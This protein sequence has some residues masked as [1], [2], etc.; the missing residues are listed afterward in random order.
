MKRSVVVVLSFIGLMACA[1]LSTMGFRARV[2]LDGE[3]STTIE[4]EPQVHQ[5]RHF[6]TL[7]PESSDVVL[8]VLGDWG[9]GSAIQRDVARAM[10]LHARGTR[11]HAIIS[12][13]DNFYPSGVSS[14]SDRLFR[15][16]WEKTY[17]DSSLQVQWIVALG[18]HDYRG[19][20]AAQLEYSRLQPRWY[21]PAPYYTT[22][23]SAGANVV[24]LF[25][26]DTDSLL[27]N[28]ANRMRQLQWLDSVLGNSSA[29]T[30][31]VIGHHPLRS[32]GFYGDNR[33]L[34]EQLKP[35]LDRHGV[36]LYLC[37]HEH[38]LQIIEHPN[39]RFT[40]VVSG[41]GGHARRTRYGEYSRAA[42]TGGGFVILRCKLDGR[43]VIQLVSRQG[44]V[45]AEHSASIRVHRQGLEP[46]TR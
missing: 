39:D 15:E 6:A 8:F 24:A 25:V 42:W 3:R 41:G 36:V 45:V 11:P 10:A 12:T 7:P 33:M 19:S 21:L 1:Q 18:N 17:A 44:T 14:V 5:Q 46:R 13:G 43:V 20:I 38:D 37:G 4:N 22:T 26:L 23:V 35:I 32:Y 31:I 16:R 27:S 40:C 9:S 28:D 29:G 34:V 2:I 30:R